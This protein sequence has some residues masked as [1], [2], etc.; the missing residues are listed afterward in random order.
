[1][2]GPDLARMEHRLSYL[3]ELG[4]S[5]ARIAEAGRDNDATHPDVLRF[6]RERLIHVAA[7]CVTDIGNDLIDW[8][9]MQD[10]S[11]YEDIVDILHGEGIFSDALHAFLR[12]LAL[13]RKP[14][15]QQ[16]DEIDADQTAALADALPEQLPAFGA[17]AREFLEKELARYQPQA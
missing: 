15:V 3:A 7:E 12:E 13:M 4:A 10:P 14:L 1:M 5:A 16:Y 17:A 9:I 6:A 2:Y 11:S 8:F